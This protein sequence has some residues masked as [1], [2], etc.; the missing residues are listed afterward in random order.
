MKAPT[1]ST[2]WLSVVGALVSMRDAQAQA[3]CYSAYCLNS[4]FIAVS[5]MLSTATLDCAAAKILPLYP[6]LCLQRYS[7]KHKTLSTSGASNL[8]FG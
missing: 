3:A 8:R 1:G 5:S 2:G 7:H 6:M 4:R